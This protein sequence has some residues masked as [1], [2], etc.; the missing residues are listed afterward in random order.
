MGS[1]ATELLLEGARD[2]EDCAE[3]RYLPLTYRVDQFALG[4]K[5][6]GPK[7]LTGGS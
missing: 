1:R 7:V 5:G 2:L 6:A 4:E 3:K